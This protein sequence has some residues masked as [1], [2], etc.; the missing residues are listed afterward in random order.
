MVKAG[1][2]ETVPVKIN[3]VPVLTLDKAITLVRKEPDDPAVMRSFMGF[4]ILAVLA[5]VILQLPPHGLKAVANGD[6]GIFVGV[7]IVMGMAI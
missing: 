2:E 4:D 1:S 6:I 5:G 3:L 7:F